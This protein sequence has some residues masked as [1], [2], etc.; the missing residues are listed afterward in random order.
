MHSFLS[1]FLSLQI[2]LYSALFPSAFPAASHLLLTESEPQS[3]TESA[4]QNTA[5]N[6]AAVSVSAPS[7]VLMEASTG[8]MVYEK[9][10]HA[11]RNPASITKIMTLILIFDA[12]KNGS[13]H[14][15]DTVTV[16][17]HASSMGGS[18]VFLE[19]GETQTVETMIKCISISSANDAWASLCYSR[20]FI[21]K[22]AIQIDR[23]ILVH[24]YFF[25]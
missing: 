18:Q 5:D 19:T 13:I 17:E 12:L 23:T 11:I 25:Y 2:L 7:A 1:L 21:T 15:T 16:S 24:L 8:A 9:D 6:S 10:S 4:P 20:Q 22:F 3:T 14:L